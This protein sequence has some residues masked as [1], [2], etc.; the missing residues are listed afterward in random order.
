MAN[1]IVTIP[2]KFDN[3]ST[4][5]PM[6]YGSEPLAWKKISL[7]TFEK[8]EMNAEQKEIFKK[9]TP[10][11]WNA[12]N[13][14]NII[15]SINK[16][17]DHF[18]GK[19]GFEYEEIANTHMGKLGVLTYIRKVSKEKGRK[20]EKKEDKRRTN[21]EKKTNVFVFEEASRGRRGRR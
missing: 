2:A 11:A 1:S 19:G 6:L 18:D 3:P 15:D 17:Q 9:A 13:R 21:K 4:Y 8:V 20:E 14:G 7:N 12:I 16:H 10:S 5:C